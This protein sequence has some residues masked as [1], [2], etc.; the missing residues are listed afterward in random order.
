MN[1]VPLINTSPLFPL[2]GEFYFVSEE[3]V[4]HN[5]LHCECESGSVVVAVP[6][7]DLSIIPNNN[8]S[9]EFIL[10]T[11]FQVVLGSVFN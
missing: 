8:Y 6:E 9:S 10:F 11:D 7:F 1:E 5:R 2:D 3:S 4:I